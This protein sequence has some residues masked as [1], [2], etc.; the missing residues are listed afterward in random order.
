MMPFQRTLLQVLVTSGLLVVFLHARSFAERPVMATATPEEVTTRIRATQGYQEIVEI[1]RD[2]MKSGRPELVKSCFEESASYMEAREV[3]AQL[4]DSGFKEQVV[5]MMLR[6]ELQ[7]WP[8]DDTR[9]VYREILEPLM[10]A[11][12]ASMI[13]KYLPGQPVGDE[14]LFTKKVRLE[15]ADRLEAAIAKRK[16]SETRVSTAKAPSPPQAPVTTPPTPM[17]PTA[18]EKKYKSVRKP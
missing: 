12:I 14:L 4:P 9:G 7:C 16:E 3:L 13:R 10:Q 15:L 6:S 2:V 8:P 5:L 1:V 11:P 17:D 18:G